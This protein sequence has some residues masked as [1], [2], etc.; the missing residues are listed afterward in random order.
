MNAKPMLLAGLLLSSALLSGCGGG[1][2]G[3]DDSSDNSSANIPSD[4]IGE[5]LY[6]HNG[7]SF[8]LDHDSE[9]D[10]TEVG[11]G[12]LRITTSDGE[13]LYALRSG[14]N[15][16]TVTG[17]LSAIGTSTASASSRQIMTSGFTGIGGADVVLR[18]L[19]DSDVAVVVTTDDDGSF[20][21]EIPTGEYNLEA[22]VDGESATITVDVEGT[23]NDIG[24]VTVADDSLY[25]FKS[26]LTL[27]SI[28]YGNYATVTG[29]I[30]VY[31]NGSLRGTGLSYSFDC[32]DTLIASCDI[33][34][35]SRSIDPGS[36]VSFPVELSFG[37]LEEAIE[38]VRIYTSIEDVDGRQWNDYMEFEVYKRPL[39]LNVE[40]NQSSVSGYIILPGHELKQISVRSSTTY[41]PYLPGEQYQIVL[42][43]NDIDTETAYS[44]GYSTAVEDLTDFSDTGAFEP[45]DTESEATSMAPGESISAFLHIGDIDYFTVDMPESDEQLADSQPEFYAVTA[46]YESATVA[47]GDGLFGR[48]ETVLFDL[49]FRNRGYSDIT[50][51]TATLSTSDAYVS[52]ENLNSNTFTVY[53]TPNITDSDGRT[54]DDSYYGRVSSSADFSAT[55]ATDTP[56]GH[57]ATIDIALTDGH[58]NSWSDQFTITVEQTGAQFVYYDHS[59]FYDTDYSYY[60]TSGNHDNIL[61][62]GETARFDLAAENTGSAASMGVVTTLSTA[63][64][65]VTVSNLETTAVD[66]DAGEIRDTNRRS[67]TDSYF[68]HRESSGAFSI[69]AASNTPAGHE[70]TINITYTDEY[71]NQWQDSFVVTVNAVAAELVFDDLSPLYDYDT[72]NGVRG[73]NNAVISAGE[74]ASFNLGVSNL[75]SSSAMD[76][77]LSVSSDDDY[78]TAVNWTDESERTLGEIEA[79]SSEDSDSYLSTSSYYLRRTSGDFMITVA[80]DAPEG[81][82]AE[83]MLTMTDRSGSQWVDYFEVEVSSDTINP[84]YFG[85]SP[86]Y[87]QV[88]TLGESSGNGDSVLDAGESARIEIALQNLGN[89]AF[90]VSSLTVSSNDSYI[91]ASI[92]SNAGFNYDIPGGSIVDTDD[93]TPSDQNNFLARTYHGDLLISAA[94]DTPVGH[95]ATI[96]VVINASD[97]ATYST[98]FEVTS[99]EALSSSLE[100]A[101]RS[102]YYDQASFE[103]GESSGDGDGLLEAGESARVEVAVSNSGNTALVWESMTAS[104]SDDYI[105]ASSDGALGCWVDPGN[106][107][108]SDC[109]LQDSDDYLTRNSSG[110][111]IINVAADTPDGHSATIELVFTDSNGTTYN[112]S[113]EV[114]VGQP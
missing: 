113:F 29:T 102:A 71:G 21:A 23:D 62:P 35:Q 2:S 1:A 97:G 53:Q 105:T 65:Y 44:I 111:V 28:P 67:S 11:D 80:D 107:T 69:S 27:N 9:L 61:N 85:R 94:A 73:N 46:I 14:N 101:G 16:S 103:F 26:E 30:R 18:N 100:Y 40:A 79:Y 42:A 10:V 74:S 15:N 19:E 4:L 22:D 34:N 57:Q 82:S 24:V 32:S 41:L 38:S 6:V 91:S 39:A 25:N 78:I 70:A 13:Y 56:V 110:D 49:A 104:T 17:T 88:S 114:T 68:L 59:P 50:G 5:Y 90:T 3:S 84:V 58:G 43:N 98:S 96:D 95:T 93:E 63:D 66:I 54:S 51:L 60:G 72:V 89:T 64:D 92:A 37:Y 20:E 45:N 33:T 8:Y 76:V 112:D 52:V 108:D 47:N 75:G 31:N 109:L 12:L 55:I 36:S 86:Y 106:I 7:R 48:G 83:L 87:D 99:G 77:V 81:H